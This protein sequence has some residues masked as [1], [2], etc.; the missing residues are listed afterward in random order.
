M[1]NPKPGSFSALMEYSQRSLKA[2]PISEPTALL[3]LIGHGPQNSMR[4]SDLV[5]CS[6]LRAAVFHCWLEK[7]LNSGFIELSGFPLPEVVEL[8]DRGREVVDL[9]RIT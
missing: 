7:L 6:Q 5:A 4:M 1:A 8:T 2:A 9:L 3:A